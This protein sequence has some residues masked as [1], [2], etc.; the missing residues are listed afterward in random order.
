MD[1]GSA[2]GFSISESSGLGSGLEVWQG[3]AFLCQV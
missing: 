2:F 1:S 3:A